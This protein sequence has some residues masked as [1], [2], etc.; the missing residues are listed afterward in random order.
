VGRNTRVNFISDEESSVLNDLCEQPGMTRY[1]NRARTSVM[2]ET[3]IALV[4]RS[5]ADTTSVTV[6]E[7]INVLLRQAISPVSGCIVYDKTGYAL[8]GSLLVSN[9]ALAYG[10]FLSVSQ[11]SRHSALHS[12]E[13]STMKIAETYPAIITDTFS[14]VCSRLDRK[15]ILCIEDFSLKVIPSTSST[16]HKDFIVLQR[17]MDNH[18]FHFLSSSQII[19]SII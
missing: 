17:P 5:V 8:E 9:L 18:I 3:D 1:G 19:G 16:A 13:Q 7:T 6:G 15:Q 12:I 11:L 14:R 2:I 4:V 10:G